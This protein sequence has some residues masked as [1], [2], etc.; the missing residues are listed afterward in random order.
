M[1]IVGEACNCRIIKDQ[2]GTEGMSM[3]DVWGVIGSIKD[4]WKSD[5]LIDGVGVCD[6]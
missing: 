5:M 6:E 2:L 4:E 3:D 1:L